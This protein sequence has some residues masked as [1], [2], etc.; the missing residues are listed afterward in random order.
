[1]NKKIIISERQLEALTR[2]IKEAYGYEETVREIAEDLNLNY[3]AT[4]GT[5]KEGGEF[6]E[7]AMINNKVSGEMITPKSLYEYLNYKYDVSEDFIKQVIRDWFDGNLK[8]SYILS[9]NVKLR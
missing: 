2:F 1:M 6:F 7:T 3:E 4:V 5:Y 9:K 8:D